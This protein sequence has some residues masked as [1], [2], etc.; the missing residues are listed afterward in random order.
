MAT[1]P[2]RP[3]LYPGCYRLVPGGY[4]AEHQPKPKERSQEA[5][6]WR[7]MYQTQDW[8]TLRSEQL[9]REPW[10]RE[11][12]QHGIRTRATDVDHI[13][14]HKGDW[15]VFTDA[16]NG[17]E[18]KQAASA[19][20]IAEKTGGRLGARKPRPAPAGFLASSPR[21]VEV[22]AAAG[23]TAGLPPCGIFSPRE[24][25]RRSGG[26]PARAR[27][28]R[29]RSGWAQNVAEAQRKLNHMA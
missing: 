13:R 2:L 16:S 8:K 19:A 20:L 11:C 28:L 21:L 5:Q 4:C 23:N 26:S 18:Q 27:A 29:K 10:C 25:R 9:L 1:K 24:S 15:A 6:A 3:C 17:N 7:W 12:A 22:F 14:D